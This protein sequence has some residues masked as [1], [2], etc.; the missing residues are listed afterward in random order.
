[1]SA[2]DPR[3]NA[4]AGWS[5]TSNLLIRRKSSTDDEYHHEDPLAVF[6]VITGATEAVLSS[7]VY[8]SFMGMQY[9]QG[10]S[11]AT[12][13]AICYKALSEPSIL[14]GS[15]GRGVVVPRVGFQVMGKKP[16]PAK[17]NAGSSH[18]DKN[19]LCIIF[20]IDCPK[21]KLKKPKACDGSAA[22]CE[23]CQ[24]ALVNE[25]LKNGDYPGTCHAI[26]LSCEVLCTDHGDG[27]KVY[28]CWEAGGKIK[29]SLL[30]PSTLYST[31]LLLV[32]FI[33]LGYK[34]AAR[35][36]NGGAKV[37]LGAIQIEAMPK[38]KVKSGNYGMI[39]A[40]YIVRNGKKNSLSYKVV[41]F[42]APAGVNP[43]DDFVAPVVLK[44]QLLDN[45]HSEHA[46]RV[47]VKTRSLSWHGI[48]CIDLSWQYVTK[49][50]NYYQEYE[51]T[52]VLKGSTYQIYGILMNKEAANKLD[53][54]RLIKSW[55]ILL[56]NI[57]V[58]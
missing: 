16:G 26:S 28:A 23:A 15:G 2:T 30:K 17:S 46:K 50:G 29:K 32:A 42:R 49:A 51:R 55:N 54:N 33:C 3:G 37:K 24:S 44:Q 20:G 38:F 53:S 35:P 41:R 56:Q 47:T 31:L 58:D 40:I 36:V 19:I 9:E 57:T 14:T 22:N 52:F 7:N 4:C 5:A 27:S 34:A 21:K 1:M 10:V 12:Q 6:G 43:Y 39:S 25:C 13:P 8:D 45:L 48:R 18:C 11:K